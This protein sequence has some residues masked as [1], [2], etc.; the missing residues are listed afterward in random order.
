MDR[1]ERHLDGEADH[2][3]REDPELDPAPE[4]Q[5]VL[6][7]FE[8]LLISFEVELLRPARFAD[9]TGD[10][11]RQI[12]RVAVHQFD[13]AR[14]GERQLIYSVRRRRE[15]RPRRLDVGIVSHGQHGWSR[16][17]RSVIRLPASV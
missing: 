4:S 13:E 15:A 2:H 14:N 16:T 3:G 10:D 6:G 17:P 8:L 11:L 7:A 12:G 9:F 5:P 1:E